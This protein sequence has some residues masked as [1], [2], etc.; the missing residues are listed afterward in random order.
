MGACVNYYVIR[1]NT[2]GEIEVYL[3]VVYVLGGKEKFAYVGLFDGYHGKAASSLCREHLHEAILLEMSKMNNEMNSSEVEEA[4]I[5]RLYT[6]MIDPS[7]KSNPNKNIGDVYRCAYA[8]MDYLLSR[9]MHETSGVRWSG[10][11]AFTAVIVAN[12]KI[13]DFSVELDNNQEGKP[14]IVLGQIHVA[15]C[16]KIQKQ[17]VRETS[18]K[19]FRFF[20]G[21]VE[22]LGIRANEAFLISQKHTLTNTRERERILETGRILL[23]SG[24]TND[25][26]DLYAL[27]RNQSK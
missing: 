26:I 2:C 16:G 18:E 1:M 20:L 7:N 15:N 27:F 22:A 14:P 10:T 8:K 6:R 17:N 24:R 3:D 9:G 19:S 23:F 11:S 25:R 21:N 5:N 4:L 13:E 12:D